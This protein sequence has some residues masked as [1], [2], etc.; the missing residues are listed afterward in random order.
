M[1]LRTGGI[2]EPQPLRISVWRT[3]YRYLR[4]LHTGPVTA[5]FIACLNEWSNLPPTHV[6]FLTWVADMREPV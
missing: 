6:G 1:T 5:W 3:R 4:A 2:P